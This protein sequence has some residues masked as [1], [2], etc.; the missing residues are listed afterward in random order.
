M[1][2]RSK[3]SSDCRHHCDNW[4]CSSSTP[5]SVNL[6]RSVSMDVWRSILLAGSIFWARETLQDRQTKHKFF[7]MNLFSLSLR[8]PNGEGKALSVQGGARARNTTTT[9]FTSRGMQV[10]RKTLPSTSSLSL[11]AAKL[12]IPI[13]D[14]CQRQCPIIVCLLPYPESHFLIV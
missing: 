5:Q 3:G 13:W 7:K 2:L 9:L 14:L 1:R 12:V 6:D 8:Y 10:D 4:L 11:P